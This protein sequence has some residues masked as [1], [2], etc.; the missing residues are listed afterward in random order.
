MLGFGLRIFGL[1]YG[2]RW[3][4]RV[5]DGV[6]ADS[7]ASPWL[8]LNERKKERKKEIRCFFFGLLDW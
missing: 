8:L 1:V 7:V 3:C 5:E 4:T 2:Q 6:L